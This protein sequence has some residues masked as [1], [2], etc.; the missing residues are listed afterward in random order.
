LVNLTLPGLS[1]IYGD[2]FA[3]P[4][5][6]AELW[7]DVE[8]ALRA[9]SG[10]QS[11]KL[12]RLTV[13]S[14]SAG[15]GGVRQ[16]LRQEEAFDR[17]AVLVMA[18]SIYCGYA[19][20]VAAR[21]VDAASTEGYASTT[22]TADYLVAQLQGQRVAREQSWSPDLRQL[23]GFSRGGLEIAGF[24]GSRAE[25]HMQHLRTIGLLWERVRAGEVGP[26]PR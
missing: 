17:I 16:L 12:G 7:R 10:E 26:S 20:D 19:G 6:F 11:W 15:F 3:E 24:A 14:F 2:H 1:K 23:S 4:R 18:D 21:R 5:V 25:D 9:E 22:E 8:R 13:S